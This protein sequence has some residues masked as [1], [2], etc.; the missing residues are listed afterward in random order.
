[1]K[2]VWIT[3]EKREGSIQKSPCVAALG[4]FDGVHIGHQTVI[5]KAKKIAVQRNLNLAVITFFPHPKEVLSDGAHS[6]RYLMPFTMRQEKLERLGVDILYVVRF[7]PMFAALSPQQF[8]KDYLLALH[9]KHVVAGFDFTYGCRG[10]GNMDTIK[11]HGQGQ[12]DVTTVAKVNQADGKIS[13]TRIREMLAVGKVGSIPEY[14][15][16][17][18][19]TKGRIHSVYPFGQNGGYLT[20]IVSIDRYFT[21]PK[22]GVYETEAMIDSQYHTFVSR[23]RPNDMSIVEVESEFLQELEQ[24]KEICLKWIRRLHE[25]FDGQGDKMHEQHFAYRPN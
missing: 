22:P 18:Y 8:V 24:H 7:N 14:L 16:S 6:V 15:G 2:T 5:T 10:E 19:E 23:I 17:F 9:V 20:A 3:H 12:F 13:S 21:L 25:I 1:M 11:G 4:F